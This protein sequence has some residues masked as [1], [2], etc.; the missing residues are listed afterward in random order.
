MVHPNVPAIVITP[1]CP[2]SLSFRPVVVPA[3]AEIKVSCEVISNDCDTISFR[4]K[5]E[6]IILETYGRSCL[7]GRLDSEGPLHRGHLVF[8]QTIS[9]MCMNT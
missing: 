9:I 4:C 2:H 3:G 1:I 5:E 6:M 7:D 8:I